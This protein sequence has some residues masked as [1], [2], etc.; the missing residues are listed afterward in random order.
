M[1]PQIPHVIY[2][3]QPFSQITFF[4]GQLESIWCRVL[5]D[6]TQAV[7]FVVLVED[8]ECRIFQKL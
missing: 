2:N 1:I 8:D 5:G 3:P 4:I 7:S 6:Y